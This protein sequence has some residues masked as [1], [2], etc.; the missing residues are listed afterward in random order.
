MADDLSPLYSR[1]VKEIR[2]LKLPGT[3]GP[4]RPVAGDL[5]A[6]IL[7]NHHIL[8]TAPVTDTKGI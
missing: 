5:F 4:P 3:L 1:N 6:T 2:G 7:H 8:I